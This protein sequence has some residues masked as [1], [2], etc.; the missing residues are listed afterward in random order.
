MTGDGLAMLPLLAAT[1][2]QLQ[3]QLPQASAAVARAQGAW[4]EI[5][6]VALPE[7]FRAPLEK[8]TPL[9]P[10][11][12]DGMTLLDSLPDLMGVDASRTYLV[13]ALNEDELR[14]GGGFITGVGELQLDNGRIAKMDFQDAYAVDDFSEPY[15]DPPEPMRRFLAVD[16]WVFRD[17]NW[18]PDFPTAAQQ[19]IALY[20]PGYEV[21]VD[22]VVAVDQYA[23][24]QLLSALGP[25]TVPGAEAPI[26]GASLFDYIHQA[27]APEDGEIDGEW[28]RQR[29]DFMGT[30]TQAALARLQ[31][32]QVDVLSMADVTLQMLE[33][34]HLQIYVEDAAVASMLAEQGWAGS[35]QVPQGDYLMLSEANLGYNK[36]S[37]K[38]QR[39]LHYRVDLT[40]SPPP[41]NLTVVYT[42]TSGVDDPCTPEMRYD[43]I[44]TEMMDRCYWAY[45]RFYLPK[46]ATLR[47]ASRHPIPAPALYG[48]PRWMG[49]PAISVTETHLI[50]GQALLL[51][52][53]TRE[54]LTF[55]YLLP[56][57][58]LE[59]SEQG[60][61]YRLDV[62]KQPGLVSV[63]LELVV[64]LPPETEIISA[65]PK[66]VSVDNVLRYDINLRQDMSF[67]IEY[68]VP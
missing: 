67:V 16:L 47:D 61:R 35:V 68:R 64:H 9:I 46:G 48:G 38:V 63:P 58:V 15:P 51:P 50:V 33:E 22:G 40:Q 41:A 19:A 18:S 6:V 31:R 27:W 62:Q 54:T 30:L 42:H 55:D 20:R 12:D 26:T 39:A 17:S 7:R 49:S 21:E 8:V 56:E 11:L 52:T 45:L 25:L 59:S 53:S 43:P 28:W 13:L 57:S 4:A 5:D 66:P 60:V 1:A 34:K 23:V 37:A 32:G 3:P 2:Q 24:Q 36:A 10:W 14:P 65:T 29:K 44:Y